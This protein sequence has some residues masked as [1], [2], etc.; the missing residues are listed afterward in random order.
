VEGNEHRPMS[1]GRFARLSLTCAV[2]ALVLFFVAGHLGAVGLAIAAAVQV[3]I[4]AGLLR[5][6]RWP[7][8]HT[9]IHARTAAGG[10]SGS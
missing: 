6:A 7:L 8:P 4:V 3:V 2:L 1:V 10:D 5:A 9:E